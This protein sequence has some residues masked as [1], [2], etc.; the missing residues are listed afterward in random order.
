M[1]ARY[2]IP[3]RALNEVKF[4]LQRQ[5]PALS[6][7]VFSIQSDHHGQERPF[8]STRAE[9]QALLLIRPG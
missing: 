7:S 8:S 9:E 3:A 6:I 1:A 4:D 5:Q 2:T